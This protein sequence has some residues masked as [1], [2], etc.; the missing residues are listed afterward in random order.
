M[1]SRDIIFQFLKIDTRFSK[2]LRIEIL[3]SSRDSRLTS[4]RY[5]MSEN[6]EVKNGVSL[7]RIEL[8]L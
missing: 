2:S 7:T 4:D 6:L 1:V 8:N 5:C 3:V